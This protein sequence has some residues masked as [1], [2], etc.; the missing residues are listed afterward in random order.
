MIRVIAFLVSL[1]LIAFGFAWLADRPGAIAVTWLGYRI[2][3]SVTVAAL[4][5][6]VLVI[7][8]MLAWGALRGVLPPAMR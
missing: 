2:E 4:A 7:V 8:A 1:A 6:L 5:L 3:T